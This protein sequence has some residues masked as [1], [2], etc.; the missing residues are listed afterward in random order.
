MAPSDLVVMDQM[1]RVV[2]S[3]EPTRGPRIDVSAEGI[4]T[5]VAALLQR[6]ACVAAAAPHFPQ[7]EGP[8]TQKACPNHR[9]RQGQT[10]FNRCARRDVAQA[11]PLSGGRRHHRPDRGCRPDRRQ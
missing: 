1:D 7:N 10:F 11:L 9:W 5:G 2:D 8:E 4:K 6:M 3:T